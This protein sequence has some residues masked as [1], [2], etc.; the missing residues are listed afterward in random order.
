MAHPTRAEEVA[1]PKRISALSVV[2]MLWLLNS[3][4]GARVAVKEGLP[5][6]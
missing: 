5:G 3:A 4:I 2:S 1:M 6:K